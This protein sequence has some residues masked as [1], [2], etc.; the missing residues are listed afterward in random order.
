MKP[1]RVHIGLTSF[2]VFPQYVCESLDALPILGS[3]S[4]FG[5]GS[6]FD[7]RFYGWCLSAASNENSRGVAGPV[8]AMHYLIEFMITAEFVHAERLT[9]LAEFVKLLNR[10][11]R[12]TAETVRLDGARLSSYIKYIYVCILSDYIERMIFS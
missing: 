1:L 12:S 3:V 4:S 6:G 9:R 11:A 7:D 8:E 2:P 10:Q 5:L